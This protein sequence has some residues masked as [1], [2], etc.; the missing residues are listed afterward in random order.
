MAMAGHD[1]LTFAVPEAGGA[2]EGSRQSGRRISLQKVVASLVVFDCLLLLGLGL[3]PL[4]LPLVHQGQLSLEMLGNRQELGALVLGLFFFLT[5][6]KVLGG[7]RT[8]T[9]MSGGWSVRRVLLATFT[10]FSLLMAVAA[11]GKVT[12]SYSRL[13]F[14]A[15]MGSSVMLLPL[16]HLMVVGRVRRALTEGAF[17]YRALAVGI[18]GPP[19]KQSDVSRL[20][21]GL[22]RSLAPVRLTQVAD[23]ARLEAAVRDQGLDEV[24]ISVPWDMAPQVFKELQRL[25]HLAAHIYVLPSDA[26]LAGQLLGAS[27]RGDRLQLQIQDRPIDGWGHWQKR[28]FDVVVAG[29]MLA[30]L[31]PVMLLVALAIKLES[32]GPVLF[33]QRR[34]GFNGRTFE[35][36]KFRSMY[37]DQSDAGAARQTSRRDSRVTRVGRVIRR[38]SI[39]ELPQLINVLKGEMSIVGPRPHALQTMAEGKALYEAVSDYAARHRVLPGITGLAQVNGL[40]G[41]LDT[42]EKLKERVRYDIE[43]IEEWSLMRDIE[44]LLRTLLLVIYD[45]RAY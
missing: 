9:V 41:E 29:G 1:L 5:T 22:S 31:S 28:A 38:T 30:V 18:Q 19:L 32:A 34:E 7:Y 27:L 24:Y 26:A 14:F 4:T 13:W 10:T 20:T 6:Q 15:W 44:I 17:V 3:F 21:R 35:A 23:L 39:D 12:E 37:H 40:R 33:R 45:P 42:I 11:A 2:D 36:L 25:D 16:M 43:Y 8:K